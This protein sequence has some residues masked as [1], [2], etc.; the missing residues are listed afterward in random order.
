[1]KPEP[2][3]GWLA[4]E[5]LENR[6]EAVEH[7]RRAIID[8][9]PELETEALLHFQVAMAHLD[10]ARAALHLASMAQAQAVA[11]RRAR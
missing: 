10:Q 11:G 8:L 7:I 6:A 4:K 3:A 5:W 9:H 1:M 2:I